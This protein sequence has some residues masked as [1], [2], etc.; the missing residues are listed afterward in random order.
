MRIL[1]VEDDKDIAKQLSAFLTQGGFLPHVAHTGEEGH[2]QGDVGN[3]DLVL[4]DIGLPDRD[5]FSVLEEWRRDGRNMPV[6]I[7]S[8]RSHKMEKI[9]GLKAGA[10][11]YITKPYDLEELAARIHANIRRHNGLA[12]AEQRAG[13]VVFDGFGGK[14]MVN[15]VPAVLT[16]IE[17]RILHCLFMNQGKTLGASAISEHAYEDADHD[18]SIVARHISNIRKKL[19]AGIIRTDSN[20]GYYVPK[21]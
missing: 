7:V 17:F 4:L 11:D 15:G 8:A 16:R 19:G 6:I 21:E 5:G 10:D 3:F 12:G 13:N 20:R 14:V 18:S 2:Y 1:I 9:R